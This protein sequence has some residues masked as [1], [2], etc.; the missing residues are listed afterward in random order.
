MYTRGM[1]QVNGALSPS[2]GFMSFNTLCI[3][4]QLSELHN[5]NKNGWSER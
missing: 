2:L 1:E 4:M 5:N 3:R